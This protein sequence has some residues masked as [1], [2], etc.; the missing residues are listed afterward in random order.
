MFH[1]SHLQ[2]ISVKMLLF[3]FCLLLLQN[4][5]N[6]ICGVNAGT[7]V[8]GSKHDLNMLAPLDPSGKV[9]SYCHI[10]HHAEDGVGSTL[11][12]PALMT[13]IA[14]SATFKPYNS[15][16]FDAAIDNVVMGPTIICLG[17]HDGVF[18]SDTHPNLKSDLF[19]GAGVGINNDLSNDHPIGFN[20]Q[21]IVNNKPNEYRSPDA[22]WLDGNGNVTVRSVL[23]QGLYITCASCHDM[24]N[25]KNVSDANNSYNYFIYSR[26]KKSSLCFSCHIK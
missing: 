16:T 19:G 24:H 23:Y 10:P 20:Y 9:C 11:A 1:N 26:Q 15:I 14:S 3:C 25:S 12:P 2:A 22:L 18:A 8:A 13:A 21:T 6:A 7:G 4:A 5:S 17:C